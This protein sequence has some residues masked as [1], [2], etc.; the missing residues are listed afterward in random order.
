MSS[1][2]SQENIVQSIVIPK[3]L[4]SRKK[5]TEW[6]AEHFGPVR[7]IDESVNMYRFRQVSPLTLKRQ[8]L[9]RYITETLPNGVM[10]V[11]G[12]L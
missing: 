12:I 6:V 9:K 2:R 7:K 5:A 3:D 10:L 4:M 1:R 11:I 8:G